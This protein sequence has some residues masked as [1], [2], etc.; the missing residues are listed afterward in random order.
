MTGCSSGIGV[1]C[2]RVF[3]NAGAHV[4]ALGRDVP[5]TIA[6]VSAINEECRDPGR[7]SVVPCDLS[8]LTSVREAAAFIISSGFPVSILLNNAGVMAIPD[9]RVTKDGLEMQFG[10]NH[11]GHFVL[12]NELAAALK[13]GAPSRIVNVSSMAH[14]RNGIV[15]D[16]IMLERDGSYNDWKVTNVFLA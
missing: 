4:F 11:V 14:R 15:W 5:K 16:D 12:T 1:E 13:A 9:R 7:V 6:V 3:A 10:T 2:V 8:N